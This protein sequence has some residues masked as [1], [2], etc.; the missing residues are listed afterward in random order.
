MF[1]KIISNLPFS[2]ALVG[3]LAFYAKRL[4]KEEMTRKLGLIFIVLALIVQSL[5]VFQPSES[6]NASSPS[7]MV[8]GG[9]GLGANRSINNF[10]SPY[11]SNTK[12]L[13][14]VMNYVGITR[15]EI[16]SAQFTSWK[17]EDKLSW[18][19]APTFSYA[20]GERQY[21]IT[22]SE[23]QQVTTIYSR[24]LSLRMD[25]NT[26]IWGWVGHSDKIGWFS[27]MQSCGNLVT[28]ITPPPPPPAKCIVNS[29][30]LASDENCKPCPGNSTLWIDD[31]SCIPNIVKTKKA[32][33]ASQGFVDASST[34]AKA[35]DRISYTLTVEN[36]G[37]SPTS[38]KLEE[39]LADVLEY[40]TLIDNGGGAL[41]EKTGVLS[42]PNITLEPNAKQTRTIVIRVLAVIPAT[43]QGTS[44]ETS[45]DCTMTNTFGN[46]IDIP[47]D[48]PTPKIV[49]KLSSELP[50]T[51]PTENMIFMGIILSTITYFYARTRQVKKEIRLIRKDTSTGTI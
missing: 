51:G 12:N 45:Y 48:C 22:N 46:S 49:E 41:E 19:F 6:A 17:V 24:P 25:K 3:Q 38:V 35:N 1:K 34:T 31:L 5:V 50:K 21:T 8:S 15:S 27:I 37:L 29:E 16:A 11:D 36:T 44:N 4:R 39:H 30:L 28:E 20:Q 33:N 9:L 23:K 26:D 10:L 40:S 43:A 7:D 13:R 18:G 32:T 47:V 2:P 14:D 42:W